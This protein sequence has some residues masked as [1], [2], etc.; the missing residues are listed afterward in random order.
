M[1][2]RVV[3]VVLSGRETSNRTSA[4]PSLRLQ[5]LQRGWLGNVRLANVLVWW[6][7]TT[8]ERK[9]SFSLAGKLNGAIMFDALHKAR[10][11]RRAA[12]WYMIVDDDTHVDPTAVADF[13]RTADPS[14]AYGNLYHNVTG[15]GN[16][17]PWC[18]A[19][20]GGNFRL[21][22]SWFTGG[23]GVLVSG[24]VAAMLTSNSSA[25]SAWAAVSAEC[26][27]GDVP[28]ACALADVGVG[29][30]HAPSLFLDSCLSCSDWLP[31]AARRILSCHAV[32]AFKSYN[33]H[34]KRKGPRDQTH[35]HGTLVLRHRRAYH[36]PANLTHIPLVDRMEEVRK[37]LCAPRPA[38]GTSPVGSVGS[39][40]N[41]TSAL[42]E[43][44]PSANTH[45]ISRHASL[46]DLTTDVDVNGRGFLG[47]RLAAARRPPHPRA[48]PSGT[49]ATT[50]NRCPLTTWSRDGFGHQLAA[51]LS[52]VALTMLNSS[53][54]YVRSNHT[55]LEH[56]PADA[57]ALLQMLNGG[58]GENR[59]GPV[60]VPEAKYHQACPSRAH[61]VAQLPPCEGP[62]SLTVCDSC[63]GMVDPDQ[64]ERAQVRRRLAAQLRRRVLAAVGLHGR[65]GCLADSF[66][67]CVHLRGPG[68]PGLRTS[69]IVTSMYA[70]RDAALKRQKRQP[71]AWWRR[72][73][74]VGME[75][76]GRQRSGDR[77]ATSEPPSRRRVLI[78]TN[79][80]S[81]ANET[82]GD[83]SAL[84]ASGGAPLDVRISDEKVPLLLVLH[85]LLFCC[86]TLVVSESSISWLAALGTRAHIVSAS[87][88]EPHLG[89][90][91]GGEVVPLRR[92]WA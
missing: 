90:R 11:R 20:S 10:A 65:E 91:F 9:T 12:D 26:K 80:R 63:F 28:F 17:K 13:V 69:R 19:A 7:D 47:R 68:D 37:H 92:S 43:E 39:G 53:Y 41:L 35:L 8:L 85:E 34:A 1:A 57:A 75:A 51:E 56:K 3:Y 74:Q 44:P 60:S 23:S 2:P 64:A 67:V 76:A 6:S 50:E 14:L 87:E 16:P 66:D 32:S 81:L 38:E 88:I 45:A 4:A 79:S 58:G 54:V 70:E 61:G 83:L 27:C 62:D 89:F 25:V 36:W 52:C 29:T 15:P 5:A 42:S 77:G 30:R 59:N 21:Q 22:H 72:A 49:L 84:V 24:T 31:T 18:R 48:L 33:M 71:A 82:F 86:S 55:A 40:R 73:L 78:H 46:T